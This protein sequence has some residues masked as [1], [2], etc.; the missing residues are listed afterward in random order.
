MIDLFSRLVV[1][2]KW[3]VLVLIL[4][5]SLFFLY[6]MKNL[7]F[8]NRFI[9]WLPKGDP[10]TKL[11]I[12]TGEKFNSNE[13][14]MVAV[15]AKEGDTFSKPILESMKAM[16]DEL[17]Q[18]KEISSVTS[19]VNI[20]DIKKV[21]GGIEIRDFLEDIPE[22]DELSRLKEY[23]L[24]KEAFVNNVISQDG[25]WLALAVYISSEED[26]ISTFG[27][28]IKPICE[29]HLG[30]KAELFYSGDPA[31]SYFANEFASSD[32]AKLV[33]VVIL[34]IFVI[35][36]LSFRSLRGTLL[37]LS[38][39]ALATVWTFGVMGLT[40]TA[41]NIVTPALPVLLIALG[42]AYGIHV[43][44]KIVHELNEV[45][46]KEE[47]LRVAVKE[48]FIPV[49]MAGLTTIVGFLSFV[50]ARLSLIVEFGLFAA[51]GIAFAM[52]ISLSLIPAIYAAFP[53]KINASEQ[54]GLQFYNKFLS[55]LFKLV[56]RHRKGIFVVSILL[57]VFFLLW[58]PRISRK[59]NF[60]EYYPPKSQPRLALKVIEE[61]FGGAYPLTLYMEADKVKSAAVLKV[62]RR[63]ENYLFTVPDSS[64]PFSVV[65]FI[66]EINYQLN[67]RYHIPETDGA[68]AN[69]WFFME[70]RKELDQIVADELHSTLIFTKVSK[71]DTDFMRRVSQQ[72]D[73]FIEK[74]ASS[75]FRAFNLT[76]LS[77]EDRAKL[78]TRE[79]SYIAEEICWL[80][81]YYSRQKV[82][83]SQLKQLL[84]R[85]V[86]SMPSVRDPDVEERIR[87]ELEGYILSDEFDFYVEEA[88]GRKIVNAFMSLIKE[89]AEKE[90]FIRVLEKY[91]SADEYDS[92]VASDVADAVLYKAEESRRFA[93]VERG[94]K[95]LQGLFPEE[96]IREKG[97]CKRIRGLL[98]ELADDLVV[99]P[100]D[101]AG[102]AGGAKVNIKKVAQS[103]LP[104]LITRLDH[105]L[106]ISQLQSLGLALVIT[107]ILMVM[108]RGSFVLG[109]ISI[110]PII[111]T[112]SII[113]GFLGLS[114]IPLD[115]ATMMI[116][117]VSIGVGIDYAIHFI[118][119]V[120]V[121][122][123][124]G[125]GLEEATFS[126]FLEKGKA[127]F[128][129]SL[130]VMAGFLV[131]LL[132]SM[133]PLRD[134]GGTMAASMFLAAL[135][136]LST[137]P[138]ILLIAKPRIGGKK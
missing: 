50:T 47:R 52:I 25:K 82:D 40:R 32:L 29:K 99:L 39:V 26:P 76:E 55:P 90:A 125:K 115:Y 116:A 15:K 126:S 33:P 8:K 60:S 45:G 35:L 1:R 78:R 102:V 89:G 67:G 5:L 119:G 83:C 87:K 34:L 44:N 97:F 121:E 11:F 93:F 13:L 21:P 4:L 68:V 88:A 69:L 117:G 58:V 16:V 17:S 118:H 85:A 42:S 113:Y 110:T 74:E 61:H 111:F 31:D 132:S 84:E 134:F 109:A 36:F 123:D 24:S 65:D 66:Q 71:V 46:D 62:L 48:I 64:K 127:I 2:R 27:N 37:P 53:L 10:V 100:A 19:I 92:E 108:M 80:T 72:V 7:Y 122:I 106:Y 41:M 20:A 133:S 129:N 75:G 138:S 130:A 38:V 128:A 51:L 91:V 54:R 105:F 70:G 56:Q 81:R 57:V 22:G 14:V 59:V 103:G 3:V 9:D 43:L 86:R 73:G 112:I 77:A 107:F 98:Y 12:E 23:A 95:R 79:A 63:F 131:L 114:G 18:R 94:W 49:L 136:A 137:L 28:V 120:V 96:A 124:E 6:Q 104:S 101:R 135:A 30:G